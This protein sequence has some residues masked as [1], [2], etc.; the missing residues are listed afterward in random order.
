MNLRNGILVRGIDRGGGT[1]F[2]RSGALG[3]V[4]IN[5]NRR[6]PAKRLDKL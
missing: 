6:L 1:G 2:D 4:N 3:W 5:Y